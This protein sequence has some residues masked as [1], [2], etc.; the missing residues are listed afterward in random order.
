MQY[1]AA[2]ILE[3]NG[4]V[5]LSLVHQEQKHYVKAIASLA[6]KD[7]PIQIRVTT[8]IKD[9]GRYTAAHAYDFQQDMMKHCEIVN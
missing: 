3:R 9:A 4:W 2:P 8:D 6:E 5:V 1:Q 7:K